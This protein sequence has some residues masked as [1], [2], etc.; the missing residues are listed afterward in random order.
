[1]AATKAAATGGVLN[2]GAA[3]QSVELT[4]P[5][6]EVEVNN[7][8]ATQYLCIVIAEGSWAGN[9]AATAV[10]DADNLVVVPPATAKVIWRN[11][12]TKKLVNLNIIA[13]GAN[14]K[15]YVEGRNWL[16]Q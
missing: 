8:H 3:A 11:T 10:V 2:A 7:M 16:N 14:T 9:A 6:R 13:S 5:C 12:R 4:A 1:M 15:C